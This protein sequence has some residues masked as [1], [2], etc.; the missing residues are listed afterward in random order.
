MPT[1]VSHGLSTVPSRFRRPVVPGDQLRIKMTKQQRKLGVW[2]FV[3][4]A[5]VE[6]KTAA[7]AIISAK[8]M[9]PPAS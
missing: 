8:I 7:E 4:L 5:S 3:G 6:G 9:D 1:I 2:K